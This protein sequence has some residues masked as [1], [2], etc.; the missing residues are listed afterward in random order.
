[1]GFRFHD[2]LTDSILPLPERTPGETSLYVCG[3][4]VYGY[5]HVGNARPPVV[6][7]VLVRHLEAQ[8]RAVKY[9][10]N[11]T[12]ID[13]K[14]IAVAAANSEDPGAVSERF[15][16]A[17]RE[18]TAAL[19]CRAPSAEPRVSEHLGDIVRHIEALLAQGF[20]YVTDEGDVYYDAA[21]FETYGKLSKRNVAVNRSE[22][23][24]GKVG[25]G[26]RN[27]PDFAL[28]KRAKP[29]EPAGARWPSPWGDGRPGWHIE[30]SAMSF[31]HLGKHFDLH[32]G[33]MDL[34]FPHH[35]NEI[36]QTEPVHGDP[37]CGGWMHN[38]FIEVDVERG[39]SF[40][41]E[42]AA[43]LAG[44]FA[45]DPELRKISKSDRARR[46]ALAAEPARS[47][48][49]EALFAVYSRKVQIGHWFQL[50]RLLE[51]VD[52]EAVRLWIL[53]THY[54]SPLAFDVQ[55][56]AQGPRFPALE[57]A[58]KQCEYLYDTW[59][60]LRARRE[61][62]AGKVTGVKPSAAA[63]FAKARADFDGA[64]NDDL[65]TAGALDPFYRV[66]S[67]INE[68]CDAKKVAPEDLAAGDET[69]RAMAAVLGVAEGDPETFFGRVTAR[70]IALRGLSSAQ[71]DALV[72]ARTEARNNRDFAR[73]DALRAELT[74]LGVEL[75]DGVSKTT[76]RAV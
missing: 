70:R 50:R 3:P 30:C 2:T 28:W 44:L 26:K 27:E 35:E 17:Y 13:D 63:F 11:Y 41:P 54:R 64:L 16:A 23:G 8:G 56:D 34:K 53:G 69:A 4:T 22:F 62:L 32:G 38:G 61:A 52:G 45:A 24:R 33:G 39:A 46:D 40:S 29:H 74:Q 66:F 31:A 75:R 76:W 72:D 14:I 51:R 48:A 15:I 58:E 47:P 37:M 6:F 25:E 49:D 9:V 10:R 7:D 12:D 59:L 68:L 18:D 43:L 36:A 42:T 19:G 65:S 55:E 60:K 1:M 20:A 67:R 71:I 57:A 5:I 21:R 73:A